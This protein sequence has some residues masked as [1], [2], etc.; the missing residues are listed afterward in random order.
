MPR[1]RAYDE[2]GAASEATTI[3]PFEQS[4]CG[5]PPF[6]LI[7]SR[8]TA[9]D[10]PGAGPRAI[11]I[12]DHCGSSIAHAFIFQDLDGRIFPVGADCV[13]RTFGADDPMLK[14]VADA[15][16]AAQ[17]AATG[18]VA[19]EANPPRRGAVPRRTTIDWD[20]QPLGE[21][22]D[23]H[24]AEKLGLTPAAVRY[25]RKKRGIQP[26][27]S[28]RRSGPRPRPASGPLA[29][30]TEE[31]AAALEREVGASPS[32]IRGWQIGRRPLPAI[33]DAIADTLHK[34]SPE[35]WPDPDQLGRALRAMP[36]GR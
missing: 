10:V 32:T 13:R 23:A 31:D 34:V 17:L 26:S 18:T 5:Y 4:G 6:R 9:L 30:L 12:C 7:G 35:R 24:I 25:Q 3:H 21:I 28:R 14:A 1:G 15:E 19:R 29:A 2:P 8:S 16:R 20:A 11:G 27:V 22:A 36:S 33:T